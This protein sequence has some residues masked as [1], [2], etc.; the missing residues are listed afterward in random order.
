M[1][2]VTGYASAATAIDALRQGAYDYVTK[3]FD[4]DEVHQIVERGIANRRLKAINRQLVE[5]LRRKNE[6]LQQHETAAARARRARHAP[7][8]ARSTRSARRSA[9][10]LEL[11]PRLELIC[12]RAAELC[13]APAAVVFL[14]H[15]EHGRAATPRPPSASSSAAAIAKTSTWFAGPTSL[16]SPRPAAAVACAACSAP[17]TRRAQAVELPGLRLRSLLAVPLVA[18]HHVIGVL[19]VLDK[20]AGFTDDDEGFLALFASQAAIA[21]RQLAALR[22]H[23]EPRPAQVRV[24]G[25][26]VARDPHA[27]HLDQGRGR[28][29]LRRPLLPEQR[30]AGQAARRSP[31][32]TPSGC[33][34]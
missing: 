2:V 16:L 28:A 24:R 11:A 18:E 5:E 22:A 19:A 13:D 25:R 27:A 7:A 15:A 32:R 1:I 4:L 8:D 12:A 21:V 10:N 20:P 29:A 31:T 14:E 23:E 17:P 9:P 34:C 33:W 3:P 26:G 30:A 6:I